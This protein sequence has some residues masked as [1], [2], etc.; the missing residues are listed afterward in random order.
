MIKNSNLYIALYRIKEKIRNSIVTQI[1]GS[2]YRRQV[3][4]LKLSEKFLEYNAPKPKIV[5]HNKKWRLYKYPSFDIYWPVDFNPNGLQW[6]YSETFAP[7]K[8]NPHAYETPRVQINEGDWVIDAGACEGFFTRYALSKKARVLA[9]EPVPSLAE[10]LKHTF[11]NEIESGQV[12]V[13]NA[14]IGI[15]TTMSRLNINQS[16]VFCSAVDQESGV[17]IP[18]FSL[19]DILQQKIIPHF[20]FIKM[21]IEGEEVNAIRGATEVL[22]FHPKLS[23]AVYHSYENALLLR[24]YLKSQGFHYRVSYRGI[25]KKKGFGKPRPYMFYAY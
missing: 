17:E 23:I 20:D 10:A 11:H 3:F 14:G 1:L 16:D 6:V 2:P 5:E 24:E 8:K 15:T 25:F 19:D 22:R 13:L 4:D 18:I 7:Y 12:I 9:I 21:D